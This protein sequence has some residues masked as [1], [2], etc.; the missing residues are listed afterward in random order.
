MRI[1]VDHRTTYSY[2]RA[3]RSIIQVL[4]LTPRSHD[5]QQVL[6]WKIETD[7]DARLR[8]G[9]DAVGNVAHL[10][11]TEAPTA[12]LTIRVSGEVETADTGGMV[13]GTH[14]R[15]DPLVFR[16]DTDLTRPD[17][18]VRELAVGVWAAQPEVLERMHALMGRIHSRVAFDTDAT[19]AG[20]S[21]AQALEL[22]RG[23]CQDHAHLFIA[24]ARCTGTPAR[25]VS[26]H[27]ARSDGV[28]DQAAAHAW[29]E[30]WIEHLG[31][32]GFDPANVVCPTE[33][34]IRVA[35]GLDELGAAPLRGAARGGGRER[36][37]VRLK[38]H[39]P[40]TQSQGQGQSQVQN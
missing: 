29:A 2:D 14:E 12:G 18:A 34:Y 6:N 23:V 27:L 17:P 20:T 11:Q 1:R 30:A 24:A 22:G 7:V 25:Y 8:A 16:R 33:A 19:H 39:S 40:R 35:V 9:D 31:W 13:R 38:V 4:R 36:M 26:G 21:A 28:D 37:E 15:L 32:V 3:T 10:L 5:G